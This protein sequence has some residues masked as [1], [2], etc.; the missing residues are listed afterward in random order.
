M[1]AKT[2]RYAISQQV[3][4]GTKFRIRLAEHFNG[5]YR[6]NDFKSSSIDLHFIERVFAGV[7][8]TGL[9]RVEILTIGLEVDDASTEGELVAGN[10]SETGEGDIVEGLAED[11]ELVAEV[12]LQVVLVRALQAVSLAPAQAVWNVF[13][14]NTI[15]QSISSNASEALAL[16]VG[17]G[18]VLWHADA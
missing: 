14:T 9:E 7:T 17:L 12:V 4:I 13:I 8:L 1:R 10:A 6:S 2:T 11:G 5:H 15:A 16:V 3:N 18:A